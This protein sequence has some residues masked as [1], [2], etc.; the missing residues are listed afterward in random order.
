MSESRKDVLSR[1]LEAELVGTSVDPGTLF[2]EDVVGWSPYAAVSG[3]NE[4]AALAALRDTAFSNVV[5]LYRGL[6]E[7][8]QQGIRRVG[9]RSGSHR[10]TRPR[11]PRGPG[12]DGTASQV[13]RR[14]GCRLSRWEDPVVPDLLRRHHLARTDGRRVR[15]RSRPAFC[16]EDRPDPFDVEFLEMQIRREASVAMGVGD[17]VDL[18][19]FVR[20][21]GAVVAGI[22]GWTWGD[23][24]E[25]QNLWVAP[26]LPRTRARYTASRRRRGR[27]GH[28]CVLTDRALHVRLPGAR[29]L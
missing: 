14:D 16:I 29:A 21:E 4:V 8:R 11:R 27:S 2:T 25:L 26:S 9:H 24:C 5:I 20:D 15:I 17:E 28:A 10:T 3:L 1:A 19:I 7:V 6:D 13:G 23:G 18:A 12:C 22:S